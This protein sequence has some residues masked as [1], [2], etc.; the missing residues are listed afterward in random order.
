MIPSPNKKSPEAS[1]SGLSQDSQL[2][3]RKLNRARYFFGLNITFTTT[4]ADTGF[5]FS[6]AG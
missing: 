1:S 2:N 4:C 6:V 5:P 3:I